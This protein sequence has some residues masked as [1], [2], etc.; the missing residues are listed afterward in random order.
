MSSQSPPLPQRRTGAIL[1]AMNTRSERGLEA[2]RSEALDTRGGASPPERARLLR[3]Y[4][5]MLR[6]SR[7]VELLRARW[8]LSAG[9]GALGIGVFLKLTAELAEG[10]LD[11]FDRAVLTTVVALRTPFMNGPA[12]DLTALGSVTVLTLIVLVALACFAVLRDLSSSAQLL[13]AAVGGALGS[14]WLKQVL[15]RERPP[16]LSRLVHVA[17]FSYPSGHSLA[18]SAIYLTLALLLVRRVHST[19]RR[20]MLIAFAVLLAVTVGATRAYLGVHYP[21]DIGAG[22]SLGFGWALLIG[23]AFSYARAKTRAQPPG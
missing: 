22:L 9:L 4:A 8:M 14:T 19:A 5:R 20:A 1:E 23:A 18:S 2:G 12:V 6:R 10:E 7:Y 11:A 21:G 15:E 16:E 17:S 3:R 13:L